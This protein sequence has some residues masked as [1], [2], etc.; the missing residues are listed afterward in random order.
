MQLILEPLLT[1]F[2]PRKFP[3]DGEITAV[4]QRIVRQPIDLLANK[5]KG[6]IFVTTPTKTGPLSIES[7]RFP[8]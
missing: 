7:L 6:D 3:T 8:T 4:G 2:S 5:G 1:R